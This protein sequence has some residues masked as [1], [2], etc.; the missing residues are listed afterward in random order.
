LPLDITQITQRFD[1]FDGERIARVDEHAKAEGSA[2]R[3]R[4]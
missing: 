1:Q 4:D 3:P 2:L